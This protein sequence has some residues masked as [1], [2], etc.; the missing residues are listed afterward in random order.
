MN[1]KHYTT[2]PE[3]RIPLG[4]KIAFGAGMLGNQM[5]PA[6][7]AIFMV[8][9]VKGL[10]MDPILWGLL[11]FLPRLFDAL[12]DPIMGFLSDNTNSQWGRRRPYVFIGAIIAGTF[13][14]I[15]WQVYPENSEAFNF[16]YFLLTSIV[17]YLG[18]TIFSTPY[19]AMGYE[20]SNDFH[21]R[22]RLMAVAQWIG[23]W[24]WVIVPWFWVMIYDP[25]IFATPDA[26]ARTLSIWVGLF[27]LCLAIVPALFCKTQPVDPDHILKLTR[28]NFGE[29]LG[30]FFQGFVQAFKNK[31]FV[32]LCIATFFVFNAFNTVAGFS[33][34]IIVYYMNA[35]DAAVAG[36]W[37]AWF[38][39]IS[40][41]CTTFLVI[42][43]ITFISQ[44]IGK[45]NT[46]L[47]AQMISLVG[48]AMFWWCFQ[49]ENPQMM[50]LPL[51]L[52]AF[53]IGSLFT[54][55]M[56]M[57]ADVCDLDELNTGTRTEGTFAA[58]YWWMVKFGFAIAGLLS[59]L[60]LKLVGFDQ[61]VAVQTPEALS[62][63]RLAYILVPITGTLI[64][65]AVMS[66]Y[67]LSEQ[68][69]HEIRL[70]LETRRGVRAVS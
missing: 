48:Y 67:D 38:G 35:G 68:K 13:Y 12:T 59:G 22:T 40:A 33:F 5:F 34:F 42:P 61:D 26:G 45:R 50:F 2:A 39:S 1:E 17:F 53:G 70:E 64:A 55:M 36:T 24:A 69:A 58:I 10:G 47:L 11:F 56:S 63:L 6:A 49:P 16:T 8:V 19:V 23:Q 25:D 52:F 62:G 60:I 14:M 54:L 66:R 43:V 32:K 44:R 9:L 21:E 3:D 37:P 51:P 18:L 4:Q 30:K 41:L 57:T 29:N 46:F 15:M 20:M 7:L 28:V 27:C 65:M 31:A